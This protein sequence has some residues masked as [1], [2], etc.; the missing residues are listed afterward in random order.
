[1]KEM[2]RELRT[3]LNTA[4]YLTRSETAPYDPLTAGQLADGD[5]NLDESSPAAGMISGEHAGALYNYLLLARGSA[6]GIHN[7]RYVKQLVYDSVE[8][9]TGNPPSSIPARP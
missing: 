7:P 9:V 3:A 1:M 8:A 5:F 6:G 2:I 4:G